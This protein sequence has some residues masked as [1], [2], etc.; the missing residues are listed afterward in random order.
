MDVASCFELLDADTLTSVLVRAPA[1]CLSALHATN[2]RI[3]TAMASP[4]FMLERITSGYVEV[5]VDMEHV[6]DEDEDED[7]DIDADELDGY[8][9]DYGCTRKISATI[10][11][12]GARAGS[13]CCTL[14]DRSACATKGDF[15]SACDADSQELIDIARTLFNERGL[16]RHASLKADTACSSGGFLYM[17]TFHLQARFRPHGSTEVAVLAIQEFLALPTLA[18]RWQV[19]AYIGDGRTDRAGFT[20]FE[21]SEDEAAHKL[22]RQHAL[23]KDCRPFVRAHF[24]ELGGPGSTSFELGGWMYSTKQLQRQ[25][26]LSHEE[27][28]AVP[29]RC[30]SESSLE[31]R[32][33]QGLDGELVEVVAGATR[34]AQAAVAT[35]E[36]AAKAAALA[37]V[38]AGNEAIVANLHEVSARLTA[39]TDAMVAKQVAMAASQQQVFAKL[40]ALQVQIAGCDGAERLAMLE[41]AQA[42]MPELH[43]LKLEADQDAQARADFQAESL[44]QKDQVSSA[45]M[46]A[47]EALQTEYRAAVAAADAMKAT[48]LDLEPEIAK[49]DALIAAGASID[50]SY[51]LHCA[52][53]TCQPELVRALVARGASVNAL[54]SSG[55]TPLMVAASAVEN[56]YNRYHNPHDDTRCVDTLLEAGADIEVMNRHGLTAL[57]HYRL[58]WRSHND[59]RA[60]LTNEPLRELNRNLEAKLRST[61]GPSVADE[62]AID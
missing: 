60:A 55:H 51:A 23:A 30:A 24:C 26:A 59:F 15:F 38:Q 22:A 52:A 3:C 47:S 50:G 16:P 21:S 4:D 31:V 13:I 56:G 37:T 58:S 12:D 41:T 40:E 8:R 19:A 6:Y 54:D 53:Y 49:I 35:R 36:R 18:D 45:A 46:A 10:R 14:V 57:G 61:H 17:D 20:P 28:M 5:A 27:A 29:L 9:G 2:R 39:K 11:V 33:P 62:T 42:L 48:P 44:S 43:Q 34:S 32:L 1:S 7:E 25:P